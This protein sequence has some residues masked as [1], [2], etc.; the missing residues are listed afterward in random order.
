MIY[1]FGDS[2]GA[3]PFGNDIQE[4]EYLYYRQVSKHFN[5]KLINFAKAGSGPD[6]AFKKFMQL[7]GD[8]KGIFNLNGDKFIFLLSAPERIDFDFL[9]EEDKHMG[10]QYLYSDTLS[11]ENKKIVD[12]FYKTNANEIQLA[13][14]KNLCLLYCLSEF[15]LPD[16]KFFVAIT[17][18]ID[19]VDEADGGFINHDKQLNILNSKNFYFFEYP[20]NVL[21]IEE[22]YDH[23]ECHFD[24]P[25][26]YKFVDGEKIYMKDD[27]LNHFS[28][29]NH[30]KIA[31]AIIDF[32]ESGLISKVEFESNFLDEYH[33]LTKKVDYIYE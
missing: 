16:S 28:E 31:K 17:F 13:N 5:E 2:F 33:E 1:L 27:R 3:E 25:V 9:S 8:K 22:F 11:E 15:F 32:F 23:E 7:C 4:T 29:G 12:F 14:Y 21:T 10:L 6:Y 20:F 19:G 26:T 18:G 30:N 24:E